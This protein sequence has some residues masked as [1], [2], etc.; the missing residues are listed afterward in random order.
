MTKILYYLSGAILGGAETQL[1][2]LCKHLPKDR[3]RLIVVT[4]HYQVTD[5]FWVELGKYADIVCCKNV[6]ELA[7]AIHNYR[8]D[9]I[10]HFHNPWMSPAMSLAKYKG[11]AI[12][13]VHG[14]KHFQNDVTTTSKEHTTHIVAVSEDAKEFFLT[15]LPAWRDR[16]SVISNGIET[17]RFIPT[18]KLDPRGSLTIL[19]VGRLCEGDKQYIAMID[20]CKELNMLWSLWIVG[21]GVGFDAIYNYAAAHAPGRVCFFGHAEDPEKFYQDAHI[22]ISRST[23]EGFGL[24]IA[25]AAASGL[26]I[27]MWDCGGISH[28]FTHDENAL[29]SNSTKDFVRNLQDLASDPKIQTRLGRAARQLAIQEFSSVAMTEKYDQLYQKLILDKAPTIQAKVHKK[30]FNIIGISNPNYT[31][32]STAV[33]NWVGE[34]RWIP[35]PPIV[36]DS[37]LNQAFQ[38]IVYRSPS[39]LI[40]G[41]DSGYLPLVE[42]IRSFYPATKIVFT[43]H[44]TYTFNSIAPQD[45]HLLAKWIKFLKR[46]KIDRIGFVRPNQHLVLKDPRAV[47]FPNRVPQPTMT[48]NMKRSS[49]PHIGIFGTNYSWKNQQSMI[50]GASLLNDAKIHVN[51]L[52][53]SVLIHSLEIPVIEEGFK[54]QGEFQGLLSSMTC[55]VQGSITES[56]GLNFCESYRLGVPCATT[57]GVRVLPHETH[58]LIEDPDDLACIRDTIQRLIRDPRIEDIQ[59]QLNQ[60]DEENEQ[61]IQSVLEGL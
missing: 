38:K 27:N 31:G 29:I 34:D 10:Q 47:Y 18:Q 48:S 60:L 20:A 54:S 6:G 53:D 33:K 12:E 46:G 57:P 23:S 58:T 19:H 45:G 51:T 42:K 25:E 49:S 14:R 26:P 52:Q 55:N 61:I 44:S 1:L 50:L 22:Y 21:A 13:I 43:W 39:V 28:K 9:V 59:R 37:D 35:V 36:N 56:F 8:P 41:G 30:Y 17:E 15:S 2:T 11:A 16:V 32:V 3:Y 7:D 5:D 4:N 24:S 40:I